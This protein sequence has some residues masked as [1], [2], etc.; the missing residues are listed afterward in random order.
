MFFR[1]A[2]AATDL[3]VCPAIYN[4]NETSFLELFAFG[5]VFTW[6]PLPVSKFQ[7]LF[8][9][10]VTYLLATIWAAPIWNPDSWP[11]CRDLLCLVFP[12]PGLPG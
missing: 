12:S 9:A 4:R 1:L 7:M 2:M 10:S 6:R 11:K 3:G 8:Q 5:F